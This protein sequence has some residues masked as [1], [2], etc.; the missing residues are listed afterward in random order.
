MSHQQNSERQQ[1]W[2][3]LRNAGYLSHISLTEQIE[4]AKKVH[5]YR[6]LE[7]LLEISKN[8]GDILICYLQDEQRQKQVFHYIE[9]YARVIE[10]EVY[11]QVEKNIDELLSLNS[12]QTAKVVAEFFPDSID[13]L[14]D[15]ITDMD[16]KYLLLRGL[17]VYN[18]QLSSAKSELYLDLLCQKNKTFVID[19]LKNS[20]NIHESVATDIVK[21][22]NHYFAL[23]YLLE[24]SGDYISAFNILFDMFNKAIVDDENV[25][26]LAYD[27]SDLCNKSSSVLSQEKQESLWFPF[28]ELALSHKNLR[29]ITRELLHTASSHVRLSALVQL[30][31][32]SE[33]GSKFGDI[34]QILAGM[35]VNSKYETILLETTSNILNSDLHHILAKDL[36]KSHHALSIRACVC[37][38]CNKNLS[39]E[40]ECIVYGCGHSFHLKCKN[41]DDMC[42]VCGFKYILTSEI[43]NYAYKRSYCTDEYASLKVSTTYRPDLEGLF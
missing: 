22:H 14:I 20:P 29:G 25:E 7:N 3:E 12:E 30:I 36:F 16:Y 40:S 33:V 38:L 24:K 41:S 39:A 4:T 11:K 37:F 35:L 2:I 18:I 13:K 34:K 17:I 26:Q 19:Y 15:N 31:V 21:K 32:K 43:Q 42:T 8:Y 27:I 28:L 1:M 6:V 23:V 9:K 10:R 5:C